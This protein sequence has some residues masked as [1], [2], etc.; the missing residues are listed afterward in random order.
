MMSADEMIL[1]VEN[2]S[3]HTHTHTKKNLLDLII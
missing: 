3:L 2:P 1:R